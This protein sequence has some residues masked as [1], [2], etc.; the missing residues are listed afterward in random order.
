MQGR[1][2]LYMGHAVYSDQVLLALE[3]SLFSYQCWI[4]TMSVPSQC[5]KCDDGLDPALYPGRPER[6]RSVLTCHS[7]GF[8]LSM[9]GTR[10]WPP[11]RIVRSINSVSSRDM[12]FNWNQP[13]VSCL[14]LY[15]QLVGG[16]VWNTAH[17]RVVLRASGP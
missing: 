10:L 6:L 17:T 15:E 9:L 7:L 5:G 3:G 13:Q 12:C 11:W 14:Q 16:R 8:L 1:G 2:G 4:W